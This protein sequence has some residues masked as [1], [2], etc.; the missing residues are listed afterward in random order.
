M[1][2]INVPEVPGRKIVLADGTEYP[3]GECGYA[4]HVLW[5][6][7]PPTANVPQAFA[8]FTDA[9]KTAEIT[10]IFGSQQRVYTGYTAFRGLMLDSDGNIKICLVEE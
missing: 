2:E 1:S 6:Y 7:L 4:D 10:F 3:R 5:C 8:D 9:A